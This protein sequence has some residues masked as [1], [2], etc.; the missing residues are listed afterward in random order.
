MSD[1]AIPDDLR[2]RLGFVIEAD[3]LKT[4]I[5]R[6]W[7]GDKSRLENSAEHS[8]WLAL[9]AIVLAP[10]AA[11]EID[12]LRVLQLVV[13]HDLVEIDAG[14]T[15]LYDDAGRE[16]KAERERAAADRLFA[17]LPEG[18]AGE[19]RALWEEYDARDTPEARFAKAL[20]RLAPLILNHR[21]AG[22][23]WADHGITA[24]QVRLRNPSV[25][26]AAPA[27][28]DLVEF[29]IDDSVRQGFLPAGDEEP[30]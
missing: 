5:R 9:M 7:I 14:D 16:D 27:L 28:Q 25:A 1:G 2:R 11:E 20:D 10:H 26:E 30:R 29:L 18:Q 12:L 4:V 8:W 24:A 19:L 13:V 3:R 15:F 17:L 22:G 23:G 21:T 6:C